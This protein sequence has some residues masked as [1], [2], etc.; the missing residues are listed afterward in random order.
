MTYAINLIVGGIVTLLCSLIAGQ[1]IPYIRSK[2]TLTQREAVISRVTVAVEAAEQL[3]GA[4]AK[5]AEKL[6]YVKD[7]LGARGIVIDDEVRAMIEA[8]VWELGSKE[9]DKQ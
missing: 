5:G 8:A 3:F 7:W 6:K 4:Q 9:E 1:L 2:T